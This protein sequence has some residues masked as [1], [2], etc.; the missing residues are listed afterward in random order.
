MKSFKGALVYGFLQWLIPFV[1]ALALTPIHTSNRILFETIMPGVITVCAVVFANLYLRR[2]QSA[3]LKE[4][5]LLGGLWFAIS[6]AIDL[7]IFTWGPKAKSFSDYMM[8]IGLTYLIYPA[9]TIGF[10]YVIQ[11]RQTRPAPT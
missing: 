11:A 3:F 8:D 10:A 1:I 7:L 5:L 6:V 2:V 4:G 9:I